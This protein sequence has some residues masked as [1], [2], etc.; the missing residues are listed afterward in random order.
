M[1]KP[2]FNFLGVTMKSQK[3]SKSEAL[4]SNYTLKDGLA[5]YYTVCPNNC[6][7]KSFK[8]LTNKFDTHFTWT[9]CI[10][11]NILIHTCRWIKV[12]HI[13]LVNSI[14]ALT[15]HSKSSARVIHIKYFLIYSLKFWQKELLLA[16]SNHVLLQDY[17][18][19]C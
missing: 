8:F 11:M 16:F 17:I 14:R 4:G 2:S 3:W 1:L 18:W 19:K 9:P 5:E 15:W 13:H 7:L 6:I 12:Q 10:C